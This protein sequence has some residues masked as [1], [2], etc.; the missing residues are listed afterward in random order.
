MIEDLHSKNGTWV[1]LVEVTGPTPVRNGDEIR[2]GSVVV[3]IHRSANAMTT[4][5]VERPH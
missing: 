1:G 4:E 2:L 3:T 5:T